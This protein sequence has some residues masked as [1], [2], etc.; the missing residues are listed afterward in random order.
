L[1]KSVDFPMGLMNCCD[2]SLKWVVYAYHD[3]EPTLEWHS[4]LEQDLKQK[5]RFFT[6]AFS[7]SL[8]EAQRNMC[9]TL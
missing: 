6:I 3:W 7:Q 9:V 1:R 2:V 8:P 4:H 5:V